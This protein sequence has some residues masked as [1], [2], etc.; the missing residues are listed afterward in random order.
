[1]S[2]E[3]PEIT[4]DRED[5]RLRITD[6]GPALEIGNTEILLRTFLKLED[7]SEPWNER[8]VDLEAEIDCDGDNGCWF[9][10][11][12]DEPDELHPWIDI[13]PEVRDQGTQ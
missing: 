4:I 12:P 8:S 9:I 11:T 13:Q 7:D 1:M 6:E 3:K 5:V 10:L 2:Q